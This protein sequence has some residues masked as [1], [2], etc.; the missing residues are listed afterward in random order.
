MN[1][2]PLV[3]SIST[4]FR[5]SL[6]LVGWP[7][8]ALALAS[9][10]LVAGIAVWLVSR[11]I[12]R[13]QK[14]LGAS[15][16]SALTLTL[17]AAMIG[18]T[19]LVI[20]VSS[21]YD[22]EHAPS[23]M[24]AYVCL[25]IGF[26]LVLIAVHGGFGAQWWKSAILLIVLLGSFAGA[27]AAVNQ[28]AFAGESNRLTLL[29]RQVAGRTTEGPWLIESPAATKRI[30]RRRLQLEFD[31]LEARQGNL[32]ITYNELQQIRAGLNV[33]DQAAVEGFNAKAAAYSVE[34]K[35]VKE[36][37]A[38]LQQILA[39]PLE[40]LSP[41]LAS[42]AGGIPPTT[43]SAPVAVTVPLAGTEISEIQ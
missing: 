28:F 3:D 13:G 6:R 15:L 37:H 30:E 34:N 43:A 24:L 38:A 31:E 10:C 20:E 25:G 12:C 22:P 27:G 36:R 11:V 23:P 40:D 41:T 16:G 17:V 7:R 4:F 35:T 21:L 5:E 9:L 14:N 33:N 2:S 42:S 39:T 32:L 29:A 8:L 1:S 26:V 19:Y 18:A